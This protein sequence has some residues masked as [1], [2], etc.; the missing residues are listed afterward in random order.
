[1]TTVAYL[2]GATGGGTGLTH[3]T[4]RNLTIVVEDVG[5]AITPE[6]SL[7]VSQTGDAPVVPAK[8]QYTKTYA[9]SWLRSFNSSGAY[10]SYYAGKATQGNYG[11][12]DMK[13]II[14]FPSMT[15]DLSGADIVKVEAYVYMA[16]WW[17]NSGGTATIAMSPHSSAPASVSGLSGGVATVKTAKPG[18][19]WVTL[20][21]SVWAGLKSG[22]WRGIA[23]IGS[24]QAAYG[25]ATSAQLRVTYKK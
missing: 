6:I 20:P 2:I 23:L 11:A 25:Y 5:P 9:A 7:A 16:H 14:G 15:G 19:A 18:G 17:F 1:M 21:S 24:G 3:G 10:N 22:A 12:G 8:K 13:G 4:Y